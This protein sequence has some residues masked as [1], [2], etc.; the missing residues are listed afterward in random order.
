MNPLE[1]LKAIKNPQQ[2]VMNQLGNTN[3]PIINNMIQLAQQGK[4]QEVEKIARN[5]MKNKGI[6]YDKEILPM[7]NNFK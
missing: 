6:D 4:T 5:I 3:N 7:L 1:I 2:Y